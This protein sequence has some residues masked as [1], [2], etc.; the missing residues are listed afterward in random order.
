MKFLT[1]VILWGILTVV[2]TS[3]NYS[4]SITVNLRNYSS[5]CA[6]SVI[7][8]PVTLTGNFGNNNVF[9]LKLFKHYSG[10]P[11]TTIIIQA[12]NNVSPLRFQLPKLYVD[13]QYSS[14]TTFSLSIESTNPVTTSNNIYVIAKNLPQI[15]LLIPVNDPYF[16]SVHQKDEYMNLK[17]VKYLAYFAY[18]G[19][20]DGSTQFKLNDSTTHWANTSLLINPTNT[21][22]Y[23]I[24][25]VWN[26]CG[27]GRVLGENSTIVKVN[28]FKI[29][30]AS[31]VP[32]V[33][34]DDRKVRIKFDYVGVFNSNNQFF[35]DLSNKAGDTVTTLTTVKEDSSNVYAT[36]PDGLNADTYRVRV[37]A[38][39]PD[40]A[41]NYYEINILP[42]PSIEIQWFKPYPEP[43]ADN[44]PIPVKISVLNTLEPIFLRFSDG[45]VIHKFGAFGGSRSGYDADIKINLR[46]NF[47]YKIDSIVTKCGILK[48]IPINGEKSWNLK[49]DFKIES[50]PKHEY[51]EGE[52]I[53]SK[54]KSNYIFGQNNIFTFNLYDPYKTLLRSVS[55][56]MHGDSL[57]A[58]LPDAQYLQSQTSGFTFTVTA[59][60]PQVTSTYNNDD[61]IIHRKPSFN[62]YYP[63]TNLTTPNYVSIEGVATGIAPLYLTMNNGIADIDYKLLNSNSDFGRN[64]RTQQFAL[65]SKNYVIK[66][67]QNICGNTVINPNQ[68]H[69]VTISQ[70]FQKYMYFTNINDLSN[71]CEGSSYEV[72]IDTIGQFSTNN[73]FIITFMPME[74][75]QMLNSVEEI[76][77]QF[78]LRFPI[79][80]H[81]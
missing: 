41:T 3:N 67:I 66:K 6:G 1:Q 54:I 76:T 5:Y 13:Y 80:Y 8:V 16:Y 75:V 59:S 58:I 39:S 18:P 15:K 42:K 73:Q 79:I 74:L 22:T 53:K 9:R 38:T 24:S 77:V 40:A 55:L 78:K 17:S 28:P 32:S 36:L 46:S 72:K 81:L 43:I 14:N 49:T 64:A 27:T 61:F 63:S 26:S 34:C 31:V 12:T 60:N 56:T 57:S 11:D 44:Y 19:I 62:L 21:F 30:N 52:Q 29:K 20:E 70:P 71:L 10:I 65:K 25:R 45:S 4:Q 47:L 69:T 35:I 68:I 37:R 23:S 7:D 2:S 50:L 51:C 48:N 33:I